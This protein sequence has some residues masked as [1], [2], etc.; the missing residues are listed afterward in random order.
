[1][2]TMLPMVGLDAYAR[3]H[4]SAPAARA[5]K[6]ASEVFLRRK[7]FKRVSDG[8][9]ISSE[10]V[11]LHYPLYWHYDILAALRAMAE[12]GRIDDP[13]CADALDLLESKR[14]ADGG[15]P[16]EARYY[17]ASTTVALGNDDVDWGGTSIRRSNPWVTV[18]ALAVLRASGRLAV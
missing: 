13:R 11:A 10:F 8:S 3:S 16:A 5:A 4:R 9:V 14:L 7:L 18:D 1:M 17:K 6:R 2:E 12:V 15:W